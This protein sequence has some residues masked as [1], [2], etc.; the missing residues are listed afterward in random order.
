MSRQIRITELL[1]QELHPSFLLVEDESKNHH[2]PENAQTHFKVTAVSS[3]FDDLTRIARHRL[4][5]S[6]LAPEF[7]QGMHAL[8]LHLF[9]NEEWV[10]RSAS[11][12]KSPAC[13]DGFN[14]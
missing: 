12:L 3:K 9:T 10:K 4:L 6:L 11:V 14:N 7:S 13:K 8:S 1:T 5:N 2:V